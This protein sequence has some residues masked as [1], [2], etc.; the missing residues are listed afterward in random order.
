[1]RQA[2]RS[3]TWRSTAVGYNMTCTM[4]IW[5]CQISRARLC[6]YKSYPRKIELQPLASPRNILTIGEPL[7]GCVFRAV[8]PGDNFSESNC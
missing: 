4:A 2:A 5:T 7:Y 3:P 8:N 1:M 6:D